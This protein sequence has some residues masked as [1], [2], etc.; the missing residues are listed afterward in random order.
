MLKS[1]L[2]RSP[3]HSHTWIV[4]RKYQSNKINNQL[5][6]EVLETKVQH[7]LKPNSERRPKEN[8]PCLVLLL[9]F[10]IWTQTRRHSQRTLST[11]ECH[12]L[13]SL[14]IFEHQKE[15]PTKSTNRSSKDIVK[16]PKRSH[17]LGWHIHYEAV[18]RGSVGLVLSLSRDP[19]TQAGWSRSSTASE[20][21]VKL[22]AHRTKM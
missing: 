8:W 3:E 18:H 11:W 6:T 7:V 9:S 12:L 21:I 13:T 19:L 10:H 17:P 1:L 15:S 2:Q 14:Q 20:S 4:L 16:N 5:W 22:V